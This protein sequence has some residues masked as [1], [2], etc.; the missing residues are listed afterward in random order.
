MR[1]LANVGVDRVLDQLHAQS[2]SGADLSLLTPA[3]SL[4]AFRALQRDLSLLRSSRLVL[5]ALNVIEPAV[6]GGPA[7]RPFRNLL[8]TRQLARSC[9]RWLRERTEVRFTDGAIPQALVSLGTEGRPS[10]VMQG[11]CGFSTDGLG[12]SQANRLGLVQLAE[13][14]PERD[15]LH[16]WFSRTWDEL[17]ATPDAKDAF[18][19]LFEPL[20]SPQAPALLYHFM[21]QHLFGG[22][23]DELDEDRIVKAATGIRNTVIW[24]KLYRFQRDGAIGAVD[25]LER[26][27]GCIV[28]DSVGLGKT[29]EALAVIKYFELRNDRVLV[30][31]PKRLRDNWTIY[32]QN[33]RRNSLAA[34]R[35]N[36]DVLNHTDLSRD[37]GV[38][39]DI[40]LGHV[41]WGNYDLVVIDESHNFR[42][43]KSPQKGRETRYGR[44][45]R[46]IIQEGVKTRVLMLSAT[47][48]NNRLA[49]LKNQLAF[50][51]EGVDDALAD[52]GIPS[53]EATLRLAQ[54]RF[55]SWLSLDDA[56]RK[57]GQLM[58]MLG[59]DYFRLLDLLTIARSR[60][61]VERY[62]GTEEMGR[63]PE[64]LPPVN[65]KCDVDLADAFPPIKDI[66]D[67]IRRLTLGAYA[68]LR[69]VL[70]AKRTAYDQ[71]YSTSVKGGTGQFRQA[72]REESLIQLMR[73]NL[74]KRM[75]SSVRS[76]SLTVERI[77]G[78][79]RAII[80]RID[81][82]DAS[83]DARIDE[84]D[85][86]E[87]DE[88]DPL[89][90]SLLVGTKVRVLLTDVDRIR[91]RQ[92]LAE[93]AALLERLF[94]AARQVDAGRDAK[95]ASLR[96]VIAEKHAAPINEG[97]RKVIVF[98]AFA[99][100]A[101]YL[102]D[103]LAPWARD[104]LGVHTAL[105]TGS[106]R[107][108][109]TL[110]G[111]RPDFST[112]L[113]AFSPR[114]KE[115]P[116]D[117][118]D[119]GELD[120]LI[121]TDCIAEGQ[122]LQDCDYLVNYDIHWNPV[123]IV[124][125]FGRIDRLG[126][127]NARI[128]LVNFWPNM[129]LEAYIDLEQRVSGR[130][131]LVDVSATG[132]ENVIEFQS[133]N[134]MN[135]LEYRRRQLLRLRD[136]VIDVEDFSAGVAITD[137]TLNDFRVDLARYLRAH[138]G[139]LERLPQGLEA[140]VSAAPGDEL[141][142]GTL[143]LLRAEGGGSGG[144]SD[145]GNPLAPYYVVHVADDGSIALPFTRMKQALD[146]LRRLCEG[147]ALADAADVAR[148]DAA[149]RSGSDMQA[150]R[151]LLAKA[152]ASIVG[153]SE[154][155]AVASLFTPGGTAAPKGAFAGID[156]FEVI[157][158]LTVLPPA[159]P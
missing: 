66:N 13:S 145:R 143:F 1:L 59:F 26:F 2:T 27:G 155:R 47:P 6:L 107:T 125:R 78:A 90:E 14:G 64:R 43:K 65:L 127:K 153:K 34:D 99:E 144:A 16:A 83:P 23:G 87:L 115:R 152:V 69:Y 71:R 41:N 11:Q 32:K 85:I 40:D 68:P 88:D 7:D 48:V 44:L 38:S 98:T 117:L 137:L 157:A 100:T 135:D 8:E 94:E 105:V 70:P 73:V 29:F 116:A 159:T 77:L 46:R 147:R 12:L 4:F 10:L 31:C 120:L 136:A 56:E 82:H 102:Y 110:P 62:Y 52:H 42:N 141:L 134:Q 63:F 33:D 72:D 19:S 129:E 55:T 58:E 61:H 106:A 128:Q 140:V 76:F 95:L 103:Q 101:E 93:D 21:L 50:I 54:Q 81:E 146:H 113:S 24:R 80:A 138:P 45:M 28:A 130:M 114:S 148:L 49:D 84:P 111:L 36:Y 25:K 5:P 74:L 132:E 126:S 121:A 91:W 89:T 122:N 92:D 156:D 108:E 9:A 118:A 149:T 67:D 133:G 3:F 17:R 79:V 35:F 22:R 158:R 97:N 109:S 151:E 53:V 104:S 60:K 124:Q 30:L 18:A 39:G 51:T 96:E 142:P 37:D 119:E 20:S 15:M 139:R 112:L 154:E 57:P 150:T 131:V 75:E 123:R 86:M